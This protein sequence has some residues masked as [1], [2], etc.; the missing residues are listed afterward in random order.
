MFPFDVQN[1]TLKFGS[2]TYHNKSLDLI[3]KANHFEDWK[4]SESHESLPFEDW[5]AGWGYEK[6][7]VSTILYQLSS[8]AICLKL[9]TSVTKC[10]I[11]LRNGCL[12]DFQHFERIP[13]LNTMVKRNQETNVSLTFLI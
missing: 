2:W 4:N 8:Y 3:I 5:Y 10:Y 11:H 1:C 6:S 7:G 13:C 9:S 12:K